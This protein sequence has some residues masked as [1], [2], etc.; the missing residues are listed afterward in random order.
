M[1]QNRRRQE[2]SSNTQKGALCQRTGAMVPSGLGSKRWGGTGGGL[3]KLRN[4]IIPVLLSPLL[5][6]LASPLVYAYSGYYYVIPTSVPL[7]ECA[8]NECDVL[9]TAYQGDRVEILER[10]STGWSRVRLVDR[11]GIGWIPNDLLTYS[12]GTTP[13]PMSP[14]YVNINSLSLRD[15][16]TP[17][18]KVLT[19][20]HFND[21]VEM[22][23]VGSSGW[24]QVRDLRSSVVGFVPP[25]YL[26]SVPLS[27]PKSSP[28]RRAPARKA[29]PKEEKAPQEA[30]AS[31]S[32]M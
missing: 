30:P 13:K 15:Y 24:A 21:A 4:F 9:L 10:T 20:L 22:L 26:S 14:Y 7:R 12:P 32:A 31:P 2:L 25:R 11:S 29:A 27:Y 16:P 1:D 18:S 5:L 23:G 3:M 6:L 17:D 28:R 19:T 8:A